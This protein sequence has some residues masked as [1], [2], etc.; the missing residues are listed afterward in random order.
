MAQREQR[1]IVAPHKGLQTV[2]SRYEAGFSA[3]EVNTDSSGGTIRTRP[4]HTRLS[5]VASRPVR[6]LYGMETVGGHRYLLAVQVRHDTAGSPGTVT[7]YLRDL[8]GQEILSTTLSNASA[9]KDPWVFAELGDVA[10]FSNGSSPVYSFDPSRFTVEEVDAVA[11]SGSAQQNYLARMP[12]PS[13]LAAHEGQMLYGCLAPFI[14][15]PVTTEI[16]TPQDILIDQM[17]KT[18][19]P[20]LASFVTYTDRMVVFSDWG[21]ADKIALASWFGVFDG[22]PITGLASLD[23]TVYV[24]TR[25][26]IYVTTGLNVGAD[27]SYQTHKVAEHVGCVAH[28][29]IQQVGNRLVFLA[30][31][32]VYA[33]GPEGLAK[34]SPPL[35][36]LMSNTWSPTIPRSW[37][38]A[39]KAIGY[40][41]RVSHRAMSRA[42]AVTVPRQGYYLVTVPTARGGDF[43]LTLAWNYQ[44]D[45]WRVWAPYQATGVAPSGFKPSAWT[46]FR[47]DLETVYFGNENGDIC[48]LN[49]FGSHSFDRDETTGA[50]CPIPMYWATPLSPVA[51]GEHRNAYKVLFHLKGTGKKTTDG[52]PTWVISSEESSYTPGAEATGTFNMHPGADLNPAATYFFGDCK[53]NDGTTYTP[54]SEVTVPQEFNVVGR[55]VQVGV[56]EFSTV[57]IRLELEGISTDNMVL[58]E[59][60]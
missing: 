3:F 13:I 24:F 30:E 59:T 48:R 14:D 42:S 41:W 2:P 60:P 29:T 22:E 25:T 19:Q 37:W 23:G 7:F 17:L 51:S 35:D 47:T 50:A 20:E 43:G 5:N 58:G 26:A 46:R 12:R 44:D 18:A 1:K 40:P 11:G 56:S 8:A 6:G 55:R 53:F 32:G 54:A 15:V 31:D 21:G 16:Q 45:S 38:S 49:P 28:R 33:I 4:G 36:N 52:S 10:F 9:T 39:L 34:V 57:A 27:T